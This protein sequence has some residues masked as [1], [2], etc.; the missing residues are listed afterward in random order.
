MNLH[1]INILREFSTLNHKRANPNNS[2]NFE[3]YIGT[4]LTDFKKQ[5]LTMIKEHVP[6]ILTDDED[7]DEDTLSATT[8]RSHKK[9]AGSSTT[10]GPS[11][12]GPSARPSTKPINEQKSL[13]DSIAELKRIVDSNNP[14][15]FMTEEERGDLVWVTIF[16]NSI[17]SCALTII[18]DTLGVSTTERCGRTAAVL[19]KVLKAWS[20]DISGI[21]KADP[22]NSKLSFKTHRPDPKAF[23][24]CLAGDEEKEQ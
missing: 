22:T 7:I 23:S 5:I 19:P 1:S 17:S 8:R 10:A 24:L 12:A 13:E 18:I 14:M 9:T 3:G 6:D 11:T 16:Q 21:Y 20:L 2:T 15:N 4:S